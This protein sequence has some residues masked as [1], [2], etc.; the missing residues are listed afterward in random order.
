MENDF[1]RQ[2]SKH[3]ERIPDK[4][5]LVFHLA[6]GCQ[7]VSYAQLLVDIHVRTE[8]PRTV[9]VSLWG[10]SICSNAFDWLIFQSSFIMQAQV[11][12][13]ETP[14]SQQL[15]QRHSGL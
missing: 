1:Y 10:L 8:I 2:L 14:Q 7:R 5:A 11:R 15:K 9:R 3:A 6:K 12:Y 4:T 13:L